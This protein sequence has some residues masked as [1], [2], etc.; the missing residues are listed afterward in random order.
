[1]RRPGARDRLSINRRPLCSWGS[2]SSAGNPAGE[3]SNSNGRLGATAC[4]RSSWTSRRSYGAECTIQSRNKGNGG[5]VQIGVAREAGLT[6]PE[7]I[8]ARS[9][10][11]VSGTTKMPQIDHGVGHQLHTVMSLLFELKAQ[12]QPLELI[13]PREG[14]L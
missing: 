8:M 4:E 14:P 12:Q 13:F 2:R 3:P 10:L 9:W 5:V 11:R 1:M 6:L 7:R